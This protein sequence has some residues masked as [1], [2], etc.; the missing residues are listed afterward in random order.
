MMAAWR[1]RC[2]RGTGRAEKGGKHI[3]VSF[4]GHTK[5]RNKSRGK[6]SHREK[7]D[8]WERGWTVCLSVICLVFTHAISDEED[9]LQ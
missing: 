5:R 9:V 7:I 8:G 1:S 3:G 2:V 6:D 4:K